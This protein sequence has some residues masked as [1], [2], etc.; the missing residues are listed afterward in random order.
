MIKLFIFIFHDSENVSTE[1]SYQIGKKYLHLYL[2]LFQNMIFF[3]FRFWLIILTQR[4]SVLF[5]F[6]C[7]WKLVGNTKHYMWESSVYIKIGISNRLFKPFKMS[8]N[9]N[10]YQKHKG[11]AMKENG[12]K[13]INNIIWAVSSIYP[14]QSETRKTLLKTA[15]FCG[16]TEQCWGCARE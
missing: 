2:N 14:K 8:T 7:R 12:W 10:Y 4:I 1:S 13:Y 11:F 5:Q 16:Y 15:Y 6:Y 9:L 3:I